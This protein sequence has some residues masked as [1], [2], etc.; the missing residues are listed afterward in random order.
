MDKARQELAQAQVPDDF[1]VTMPVYAGDL[2]DEESTVL[3]KESLA[4]LGIKVTLQKRP[5][6]QKRS[7]LAKKQVDMAVYDWRPWVPDAGYFIYWNWLSDSFSNL[8][9]YHNL[10]AQALG[11][12]TITLPA[13]APERDAKLRRFQEVVNSEVGLVPLFT[14]FDNIVM[15]EHVQGYV[16]YPDTVPILAKMRLG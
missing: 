6:S 5:I 15:R 7:L 12:D 8:W 14:Q 4:Q 11:N 3:I 13:G 9:N 1:S 10:D 2:F 16:Y